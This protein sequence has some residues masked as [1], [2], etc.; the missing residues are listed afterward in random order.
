MTMSGVRVRLATIALLLLSAI[1]ASLAEDSYLSH[2]FGARALGLGTAYV[3]VADDCQAALWNPAGLAQ[4]SRIGIA[5]SQ[6]HLSFTD[7]VYGASLA[8]GLGKYGTASMAVQHLLVANAAL[9][10]PVLDAD[11]NPV[12]DPS[13]NQPL[14]EITG[15]GQES[16]GTFL[17]G[18]GFAVSR[19]LLVGGAGKWLVGMAGKIA[20]QGLG[21]DAGM[22]LRLPHGWRVG[23]AVDDLGQTTVRWRDGARTVLEPAGRFGVA[24]DLQ[25]RWLLVASVASALEKAEIIAAAGAEWKFAEFLA[26]RAGLDGG[27]VT[28]GVGFRMALGQTGSFAS[29][30]YAFVTGGRYEDRNRL[31]LGVTF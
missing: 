13:T 31:T 19:W 30:D 15:F 18:Y 28:G 22:L 9:T 4:V 12:L 14:V 10:R 17:L 8:A 21:A 7:N 23:L 16:D 27:R 2:E 29:A 11:G 3:A 5:G 20:G 24:W 6:N 26:F 25:P 1:S